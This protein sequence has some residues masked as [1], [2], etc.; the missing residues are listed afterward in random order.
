[1]CM[2]LLRTKS[3]NSRKALAPD[4]KEIF[5]NNKSFAIFTSSSTETNFQC[6]LL[7]NKPLHIP[8]PSLKV[9]MYYV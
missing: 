1:M 3:N 6:N 5:N 9:C 2:Y 7:S 8:F 4:F